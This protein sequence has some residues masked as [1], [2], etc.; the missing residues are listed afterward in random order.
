MMNLLSSIFGGIYAKLA[1]ALT[2]AAGALYVFF[3]KS[4]RDNLKEEN[5]DLKHSRKQDHKKAIIEDD[6]RDRAR[7]RSTSMKKAH[8][9]NTELLESIKNDKTDNHAVVVNIKRLLKHKDKN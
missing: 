7:G 6:L 3:L 5:K 2:L 1:G 4:D 8:Q 9:E